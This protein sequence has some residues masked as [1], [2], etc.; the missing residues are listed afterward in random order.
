MLA[1]RL[2]SYANAPSVPRRWR[3]RAGR[4]CAQ[5]T[6]TAFLQLNGRKCGPVE[7]EISLINDDGSIYGQGRL[8]GPA[9]L[10]QTAYESYDFLLC[11]VEEQIEI[12]A[13]VRK[14]DAN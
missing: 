12:R 1:N 4:V 10:L 11:L 2:I 6:G 5:L 9:A 7:Y 14:L 8:E 13:V 3:P